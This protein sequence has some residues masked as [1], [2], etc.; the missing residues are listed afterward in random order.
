MIPQRAYV[1]FPT[2]MVNTLRGILKYSTD[3]ESAN[4]FGGDDA[5]RPL[6]FH[7]G[8]LVKLFR[9]HRRAINICEYLK[10]VSNP[11]IITIGRKPVGNYFLTHLA[12]NERLDHVLFQ[13]HLADPTVI[14]YRHIGI[15]S[16]QFG[17][18][19]TRSKSDTEPARE[20]KVTSI[21]VQEKILDNAETTL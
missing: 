21:I 19:R 1:D 9:V 16:F 13:S 5:H 2:H 10:F 7:E 6:E 20:R 8:T 11:Q 14:L 15:P 3:L 4:E 18:H 17:R 12:F